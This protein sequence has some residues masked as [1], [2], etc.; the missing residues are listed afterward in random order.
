[1]YKFLKLTNNIIYFKLIL[2]CII[3][4]TIILSLLILL[5][6]N[7]EVI[8]DSLDELVIK[9]NI[10]YKEL[11]NDEH[12]VEFNNK[13]EEL[14]TYKYP[15]FIAN[16]INSDEY[17]KSY[18]TKE[19]KIVVTFTSINDTNNTYTLDV[20]YNEVIKYINYHVEPIF[21]YKNED[22]YS[23]D[24]NKKKIAITFDDGPHPYN[25]PQILR[26]LNEN[27]AKGTF[28][29]LGNRMDLHRD[30]VKTVKDEGHEIGLHG[31]THRSFRS[32]SQQEVAD[33]LS[34]SNNILFEVTG[35]NTTLVRPPYGAL[36][37]DNV[38]Q[39]P[40]TYILWNN[41]TLDWKNRDTNYIVNHVLSTVKD[42]DIIL[43]HDLFT[44]SVDALNIL[45]PELYSRGY[46]VVTVSELAKEK[47]QTIELNQ[48]YYQF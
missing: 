7:D 29:M 38:T 6:T 16:K 21:N 34:V 37:I 8:I 23:I 12:E 46:Q 40:Y 41:D 18:S 17:K 33:E 2:S 25:T 43:L 1:M 14:V 3:L 4:L 36:T 24:P 27:K 30:I 11:V 22:G 32:I 20:Y 35:T 10:D 47:N 19:D 48:I 28:F 5:E 9:E 26:I 39:L 45:L 15:L 31:I 42:G 13:I 44:T